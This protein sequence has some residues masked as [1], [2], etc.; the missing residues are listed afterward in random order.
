MTTT[1][2]FRQWMSRPLGIHPDSAAGRSFG[3]VIANETETF[4]VC[5]CCRNSC[6]GIWAASKNRWTLTTPIAFEEFLESL[7]QTGILNPKPG[8]DF[9]VRRWIKACRLAAS[10]GLQEEQPHAG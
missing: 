3:L 5:W 7:N 4:F 2:E 9:G 1:A 6:G 10:P 8:D